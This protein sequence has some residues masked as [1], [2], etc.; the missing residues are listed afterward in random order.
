MSRVARGRI[1]PRLAN[2]VRRPRWTSRVSMADV[3]DHREWWRGA[4]IYQIYPRS[5]A[6]GN[7]DGVGD[8][9]GITARLDYVTGLGA[10]AIWL[11][12]IFPSPMAD[13]GYDV[14]DYLDVDPLFG[15]IEDLDLLVAQ[16]HARG[17]RVILDLVPNHTSDEHPW[18]VDARSSRESRYRDWYIWR[19]GRA[20][21]SPP[22]NWQSYFGGSAWEWD[23]RTAQFYLHLFD[24]KQPDLN[25]RN[26]RVREAIYEVIRFWFDRG[27]DGLRID[28]LWLLVKDAE[29]RDNPPSP[30]LRHGEYE[31]SRYDRPGFEDRPEVHDIVREM[32]SVADE[33]DQRV[34]IGEIYLPLERLVRYYG[35]HLS[36]IHLPFNF[37]LITIPRW[38]ATTIAELIERYEAALPAGAAPNWVLGNHDVPRIATRAG[39]A[40]ARLAL[41]LL[42]TLRGTATCYYG[43]EIGLQNANIPPERISDP[44]ARIGKSRD[45]ARTPMQWDADDSAGFSS[46]QIQPWLPLTADHRERNVD[47][48]DKDPASELNLFR[49]LVRLRRESPALAH[50]SYRAVVAGDHDL[51][52]YVREHQDER[53]LVALNFASEPRSLDLRHIG[54]SSKLLCST[55]PDRRNHRL[56][57]LVLDAHEGALLRLQRT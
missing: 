27:I 22:N 20:D 9:P 16:A 14:A 30:P 33:Y 3:L 2:A 57:P 55:R 1:P 11:S 54:S 53:D 32:R 50:G 38:D 39:T 6:D 23:E 31:W 35:E 15:T 47:A 46:P 19:D 17:L 36:G 41:M 44:Q 26:P 25:W 12:P 8:L 52:V 48:Q 34:L 43:D 5:F 42:L 28:V 24:R 10:D 4:V 37:G 49:Q 13:F 40:G 29:F 7:G 18:F 51:L 45:G 21:G 56:D